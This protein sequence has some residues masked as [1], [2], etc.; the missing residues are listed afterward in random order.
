MV[1]DKTEDWW[2]YGNKPTLVEK[3]G[4]WD[5]TNHTSWVVRSS[6]EYSLFPDVDW[7]NSLMKRT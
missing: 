4:A 3:S 7:K 2:F 6:L 5:I 1:K